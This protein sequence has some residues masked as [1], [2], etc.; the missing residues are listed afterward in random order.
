MVNENNYYGF[1]QLEDD[2]AVVTLNELTYLGCKYAKLVL[3][4][5]GR[6]MEFTTAESS[7]WFGSDPRKTYE[8]WDTSLMLSSD[9][10]GMKHALRV[11]KEV[12]SLYLFTPFGTY[13]L[14]PQKDG[15]KLMH[16]INNFAGTFAEPITQEVR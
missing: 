2:V 15:D 7:A 13:R 14:R 3:H 10:K 8:L 6:F 9:G 4:F 16:G 12:K 5:N 1:Q 11:P